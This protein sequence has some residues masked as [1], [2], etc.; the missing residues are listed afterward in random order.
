MKR[1][2]FYAESTLNRLYKEIGFRTV[3][4]IS[5]Y[6]TAFSNL[7]GIIETDEAWKIIEQYFEIEDEPPFTKEEFE[8]YLHVAARDERNDF[9]V[10]P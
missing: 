1:K 6:V 3:D 4:I 8:A 9:F 7:Y 2:P 10:D 5:E